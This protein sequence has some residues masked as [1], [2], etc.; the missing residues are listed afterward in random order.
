MVTHTVRDPYPDMTPWRYAVRD[1]KENRNMHQP[2][3]DKPTPAA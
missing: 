1:K 3:S 2:F